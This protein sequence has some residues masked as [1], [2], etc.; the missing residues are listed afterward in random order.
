MNK[1]DG[2]NGAVGLLRDS[3]YRFRSFPGHAPTRGGW[4]ACDLPGFSCYLHSNSDFVVALI[5]LLARQVESKLTVYRISSGTTPAEISRVLGLCNASF[6][7]LLAIFWQ[8]PCVHRRSAAGRRTCCRRADCGSFCIH[9]LLL[10][11]SLFA[12][13]GY[14]QDSVYLGGYHYSVRH[15]NIGTV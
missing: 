14:L 8:L 3:S 6:L 4:T 12:V 5:F 10:L 11:D 13:E 7:V 1:I 2:E 9:E 15:T